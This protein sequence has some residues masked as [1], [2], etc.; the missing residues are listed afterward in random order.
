MDFTDIT[1]TSNVVF[2]VDIDTLFICDIQGVPKKCI[3][4]SNDC[5]LSFT[6]PNLNIYICTERWD[7]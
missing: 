1:L 5:K 7:D 6:D 2:D 4:S 3:H